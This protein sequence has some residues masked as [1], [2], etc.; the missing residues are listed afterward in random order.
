MHS[1]RNFLFDFPNTQFVASYRTR[2]QVA[3]RLTVVA[4]LG[5]RR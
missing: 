1:N 2:R 5:S 3:A 4:D